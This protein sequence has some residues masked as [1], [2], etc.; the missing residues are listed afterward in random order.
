MLAMK[1][2]GSCLKQ[3]RTL[4][5]ELVR[6]GP[7]SSWSLSEVL[8][9]L[10][11]VKDYSNL[12]R[13]LWMV[14]TMIGNISRLVCNGFWQFL[15]DFFCIAFVKHV[16]KEGCVVVLVLFVLQLHLFPLPQSSRQPVLDC[17][18]SSLQS[19]VMEEGSHNGLWHYE[20]RFVTAG[21]H[22]LLYSRIFVFLRIACEQA[23]L[24]G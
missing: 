10:A 23:H 1:A 12:L 18:V 5:S 11:L 9:N 21:H 6:S 8:A 17:S 2:T 16:V 4:T 13:L 22:L 24:F 14:H 15:W 3:V 20:T 7:C 19:D